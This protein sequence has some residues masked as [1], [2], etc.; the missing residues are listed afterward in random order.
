MTS[1]REDSILTTWTCSGANA[2]QPPLPFPYR[3]RVHPLEQEHKRFMK[4][5][6]GI[7]INTPFIKYLPK[8]PKYAKFLQDLLYTC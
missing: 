6:K 4:Q 1:Q 2:Y 3:A 7:L 5:V 8:V